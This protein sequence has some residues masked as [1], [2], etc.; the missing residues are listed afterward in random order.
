[1]HT[2]TPEA[3]ANIQLFQ[4]IAE[5]KRRQEIK[6]A[7][8][9]YKMQFFKKGIDCIEMKDMSKNK[10]LLSEESNKNISTLLN[11][12]KTEDNWSIFVHKVPK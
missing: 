1:M 9:E 12:E 4:R 8:H 6:K 3:Y 7:N 2:L 11:K 10:Q 5:K